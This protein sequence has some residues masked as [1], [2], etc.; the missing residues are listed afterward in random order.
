MKNDNVSSVLGA[1]I[2]ENCVQL[3]RCLRGVNSPFDHEDRSLKTRK[4]KKKKKRDNKNLSVCFSICLSNLTVLSDPQRI[5]LSRFVRIEGSHRS[6]EFRSLNWALMRSKDN[7][8]FMLFKTLCTYVL[9]N[10]KFDT[11][12]QLLRS[13]AT[14]PHLTLRCLC[15]DY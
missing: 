13:S 15:K 4:K 8:S 14:V 5:S 2:Y 1:S 3:L 12:Q 11:S 7:D 6:Y 10:I 9:T